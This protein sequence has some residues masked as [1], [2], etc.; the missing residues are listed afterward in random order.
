MNN[1]IRV[2]SGVLAAFSG[3]C[4]ITGISLLVYEGSA[5]KHGTIKENIVNN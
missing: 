4:L 1:K 2:T 3:L 5:D